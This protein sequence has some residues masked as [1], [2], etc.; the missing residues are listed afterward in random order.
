LD[1]SIPGGNIPMENITRGSSREHLKTK[2]AVSLINQ[3]YDSGV[4]GDTTSNKEKKKTSAPR[5]GLAYSLTDEIFDMI[6]KKVSIF[7]C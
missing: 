6:V 4:I 3:S 2:E 7:H 5:T 1:N